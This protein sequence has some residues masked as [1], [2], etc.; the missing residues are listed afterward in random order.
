[1]SDSSAARILSA[2]SLF[3]RRAGRRLFACALTVCAATGTFAAESASVHVASASIASVVPG[4]LA[5]AQWTASRSYSGSDYRFSFARGALDL[6]VRFDLPPGAPGHLDATQQASGPLMQP[7]P[8]FELGLRSVSLKTQPTLREMAG[9]ET[10]Q[11][12]VRRV[13]LQWKPASELVFFRQGVGV[14]LSGDDR[15]TMRLKKGLLGIYMK[16]DF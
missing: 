14:R 7:L 4:S 1:M 5:A 6:G 12:T 8:A 3:G 16:Q 10:A 9:A 13:G 11:A 2:R 15:V